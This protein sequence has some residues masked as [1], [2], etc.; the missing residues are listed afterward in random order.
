[1]AE[2]QR[3]SD[4]LENSENQLRASEWLMARRHLGRNARSLLH[5]AD[6]PTRLQILVWTVLVA[7]AIT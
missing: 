2:V 5:A 3:I 4:R 7:I 6:M 1:M